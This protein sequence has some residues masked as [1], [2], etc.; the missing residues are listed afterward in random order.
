[1][2]RHGQLPTPQGHPAQQTSSQYSDSK[3]NTY[4]LEWPLLNG[5]FRVLDYV[6]GDVATALDRLIRGMNA[7]FHRLGDQR[8]N[9]GNVANCRV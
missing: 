1:M 2:L 3:S 9:F 6:L 8:L 5:V 7:V 4:G